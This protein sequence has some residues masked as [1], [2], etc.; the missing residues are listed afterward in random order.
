MAEY[1]SAARGYPPSRTANGNGNK[2]KQQ[3]KRKA[4]AISRK[5]SQL[6][7]EPSEDEPS[8][9]IYRQPL[10]T[11]AYFFAYTR[12]ELGEMLAN[13]AK[14]VLRHRFYAALSIL[15]A[16]AITGAT[17][18]EGPH[19][20]VLD[21][22]KEQVTW[23]SWWA[24]LGVASSVGL[25]SGLHTFVLFL[26]PHI[27][28]V[29][30]V[31]FKCGGVEFATR[32]ENKF[33]CDLPSH[34]NS[35]TSP[36]R[37][38]RRVQLEIFFWGIGTAIGELP[39]YFIARAAASSGGKSAAVE[40]LESISKK[41]TSELTIHDRITVFLRWLLKRMGFFGILL[42]ASIPNPAF[43]LA[44]ITCGHF[45][46]PF[47][48][49]FGATLL[50][51]AIV[52]A[53]VQGLVVVLLSSGDTLAILLRK[54]REWWP[55]LHDVV[56]EVIQ[57]QTVALSRGQNQEA[58]MKRA[59]LFTRL[60]SGFVILMLMYFLASIIESLALTHARRV[61]KKKKN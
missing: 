12:Q 60:W 18:I 55:W 37:V 47:W 17:K 20:M 59:G 46:V 35:T 58:V 7:R 48:T 54:L 39:P 53:T 14:I 3:K 30:L 31:A 16:I 44:G 29:S 25:G 38:F 10:T 40:E 6:I 61:W 57:G 2:G 51:K 24:I 28:E 36:W 33:I 4:M 26:A 56:E 21:I 9:S 5:R 52:K 32:G 22:L 41:K 49:F 11:L 34:L 1:K 23:Y 45:Q 43:D 13:S 15:G 8:L 27:A 50:G 42:F 19:R